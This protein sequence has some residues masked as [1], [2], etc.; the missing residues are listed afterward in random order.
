MCKKQLWAVDRAQEPAEK[1]PS[2]GAGGGGEGDDCEMS[3]H[4]RRWRDNTQED[5]T[6]LSSGVYTYQA[7]ISIST[8]KFMFFSSILMEKFGICLD[9]GHTVPVPWPPRLV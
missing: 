9:N 3:A 6:D 1:A 2:D 4:V 5:S 8:W 7:V